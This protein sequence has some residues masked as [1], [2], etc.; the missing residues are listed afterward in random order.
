MSTI[1]HVTSKK[2]AQTRSLQLST[3]PCMMVEGGTDSHAAI[4]TLGPHPRTSVSGSC[5]VKLNHVQKVAKDVFN[6]RLKP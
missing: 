6:H 1:Y 4:C 2:V 5:K 3:E